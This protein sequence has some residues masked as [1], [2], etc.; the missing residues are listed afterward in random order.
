MTT[1]GARAYTIL[2]SRLCAPLSFI[3]PPYTASDQ[4]LYSSYFFFF[5]KKF[6]IENVEI[7]TLL[8]AIRRW[9]KDEKKIINKKYRKGNKRN[10]TK[11]KS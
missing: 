10:R 7:E 5:S 2:T 11:K 8:N 4:L 9:M 1:S 6:Q 3:P